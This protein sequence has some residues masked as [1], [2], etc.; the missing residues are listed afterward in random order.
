MAEAAVGEAVGEA[1]GGAEVSPAD[2]HVSHNIASS[3][4]T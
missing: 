4:H 1:V 2:M 3:R